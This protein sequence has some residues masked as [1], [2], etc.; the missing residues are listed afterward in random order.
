MKSK[1][2]IWHFAKTFFFIVYRNFIKLITLKKQLRLHDLRPSIPPICFK[3]IWRKTSQVR[4]INVE[5]LYAFHRLNHRRE[6]RSLYKRLKE[7]HFLLGLL[8][9]QIQ[10]DSPEKLQ[11]RHNKSS[12]YKWNSQRNLE[13]TYNF[14]DRCYSTFL[15]RKCH[16]TRI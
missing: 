11:L 14:I 5:N 15:P 16:K 1:L 7:K 4:L 3:V 2:K 6:T 13:K 8:L 9:F 10:T 12:Y